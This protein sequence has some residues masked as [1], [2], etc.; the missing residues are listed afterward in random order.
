MDD[1]RKKLAKLNVATAILNKGSLFVHLDPRVREVTVPPWLQHQPQ[2]VLQLGWD[3]PIPIPDLRVDKQGISGTLSFSRSPFL[4]EVP[5]NAVFALVG[6]EGQGMV[7][8][9]YIP[10][11]IVAEIE[12][13]TQKSTVKKR[14][15]SSTPARVKPVLATS[16]PPEKKAG[17]IKLPPYL[18]VVK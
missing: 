16:K 18:R 8:E 9:D 14:T 5:W 6:D 13:E 12:Q 11:E 15:S 3:M 10:A 2:L 7:W 4:C 1:S 17:K